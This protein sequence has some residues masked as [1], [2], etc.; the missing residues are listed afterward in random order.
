MEDSELE[1]IV[2][3]ILADTNNPEK[4]DKEALITVLK[5]AK[6]SKLIA[7]VS[8]QAEIYQMVNDEYEKLIYEEQD[9]DQT[10]Q[11]MHEKA[12]EIIANNQ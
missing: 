9:I 1:G 6:S 11:A 8:Y 3:T 2:D 10:I 7:P 4:V 5:N 12:K